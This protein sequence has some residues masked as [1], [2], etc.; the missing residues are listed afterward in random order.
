MQRMPTTLTMII[1]M[2]MYITMQNMPPKKK[3][4][5]SSRGVSC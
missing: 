3:C 5:C 2:I 1:I 4:R